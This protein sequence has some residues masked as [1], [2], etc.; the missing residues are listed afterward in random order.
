MHDEA[1]QH[2]ADRGEAAA[3]AGRPELQVLALA[4]GLFAITALV[5]LVIPDL[6]ESI[7]DAG[8]WAFVLAACCSGWSSTPCS[9]SSS[10]VRGSRSR[11]RRSRLPSRWCSSRRRWR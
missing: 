5:V 7:R 1:A 9:T 11:C 3:G 2:T 6:G 4:V 10:G 8:P